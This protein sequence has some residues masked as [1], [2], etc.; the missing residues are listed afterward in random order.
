MS[1]VVFFFTAGLTACVVALLIIPVVLSLAHRNRWYDKID[2]RKIHAAD[3]PRLGG[4]G[5]FS[6]FVLVSTVALVVASANSNFHASG[7]LLRIIGLAVGLLLIHA[8]GLIDDFT[9]IRA[10][11]KLIGQILAASIVA[12]SGITINSL[13]FG[14]FSTIT[15]GPGAG[16][17]S[18]NLGLFAY[19]VTV[20]WIIGLSNA[21][22]LVDGLDGYA[23]GISATAALFLG[24]AAT[25]D[26]NA[27]QAVLSFVLFGAIIGFL[28]FNFPP[29]RIFM[30]DSGSLFLGFAVAVI[31]LI[32]GERG[33]RTMSLVV[34]I[35]LLLIPILDTIYAIVRRVRQRRPI[36]SPDRGH[37]HHKLLELGLPTRTILAIV[38]SYCMILGIVAL[39]EMTVKRPWNIV[40]TLILWGVATVLFFIPARVHLLRRPEENVEVEDS[41]G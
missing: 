36:Y 22:N 12:A 2:D 39:L 20:L 33:A 34:P 40:V 32:P 26:A 6:S 19:P 16:V 38:Y 23:G 24:V 18:L 5:M 1:Q 7:S 4:I 13:S 21:M 37:L 14:G 8:V 15:G 35:S 25:V 29:A 30:G 28:A 11:V 31:P 41:Q 3:T 9:N 27:I 17:V 10:I